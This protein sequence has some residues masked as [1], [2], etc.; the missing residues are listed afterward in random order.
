M[1][2]DLTNST[3]ANPAVRVIH[4]GTGDGMQ[5]ITTAGRGISVLAQGGAPC[6]SCGNPVG[7]DVQMTGFLGPF[8]GTA[9]RG[10][11]LN[12]VLDLRSAGDPSYNGSGTL[13]VIPRSGAG[14]GRDDYEYDDAA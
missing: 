6:E 9:I 13:P 11:G 4:S 1:E 7:L 12:A 2:V 3:N 14:D 5:V 8:V 10:T